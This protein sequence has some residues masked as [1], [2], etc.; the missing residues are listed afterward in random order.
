MLDKFPC[1]LY[2]QIAHQARLDRHVGFK[3]PGN[4][5]MF[6]RFLSLIFSLV[7]EFIYNYVY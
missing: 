7:L 1:C 2:F 5:L 3:K 6:I 4:E